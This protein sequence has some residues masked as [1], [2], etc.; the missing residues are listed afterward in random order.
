MKGVMTLVPNLRI[1]RVKAQ[2][3]TRKCVARN[4]PP[5]RHGCKRISEIRRSSAPGKHRRLPCSSTPRLSL[6]SRPPLPPRRPSSPELLSSTSNQHTYPH[7]LSFLNSRTQ[8]QM[9]QRPCPRQ[10]TARKDYSKFCDSY[11]R[12]V[13]W[14]R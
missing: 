6:S 2:H 14:C 4:R 13:E 3:F 7:L 9:C 11:D 8:K 12:I 5:T 1:I 10:L